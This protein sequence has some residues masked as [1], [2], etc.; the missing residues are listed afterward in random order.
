MFTINSP[1]SYH[2]I[3]EL[4]PSNYRQITAIL[5][6]ENLLI[7]Y[8]LFIGRDFSIYRR[9]AD[10]LPTIIHQHSENVPKSKIGEKMT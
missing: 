4:L 3:Y 9:V 5:I 1:I 8:K 10:K 2:H 7:K 6:H